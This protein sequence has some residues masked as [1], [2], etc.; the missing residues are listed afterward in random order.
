MS[1]FEVMSMAERKELEQLRSM[2]KQAAMVWA[3]LDAH[4][5]MNEIA[6]RDI[7][8]MVAQMKMVE[9]TK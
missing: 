1:D 3:T 2:Y 4:T 5:G 6:V 9:A 8:E 7:C